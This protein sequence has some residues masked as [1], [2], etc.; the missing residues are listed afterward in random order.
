M[1]L[2]SAQRHTF[3]SQCQRLCYSV[4]LLCSCSLVHTS[5]FARSRKQATYL[6]SPR[7]HTVHVTPERFLSR[8]WTYHHE[9]PHLFLELT[10]MSNNDERPS[11][12]GSAPRPARSSSPASGSITQLVADQF[13][14][15]MR[16]AFWDLMYRDF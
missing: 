8:K 3:F 12:S 13:I 14:Q 4:C 11:D 5:A 15:T 16:K 10:K 9:P 6:C 1:Q 2:V 7:N